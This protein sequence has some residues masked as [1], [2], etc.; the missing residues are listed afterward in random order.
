LSGQIDN[1]RQSGEELFETN[2]G[3]PFF[4]EN[5]MF[6][7]T[8]NKSIEVLTILLLSV[9]TI[10]VPVEVFLRYCF[11]M[12]LNITEQLTRYLLVWVVFLA[13]SLAL[14]ENSH[15]SIEILANRFHGRARLLVNLI[16]Q[17]V[18]ITFLAFLI[19]EGI[20]AL[21]FQKDQIV[22]SL[23]ISIFWFYLAIPV[24]S[25]LMIL[26]LLPRIW[27]ILKGISG[28]SN[29]DQKDGNVSPSEPGGFL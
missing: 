1:E 14:R 29:L 8:L 13:S 25:S 19:V 22:P 9:I 16:S 4:L 21:S 24:G 7:R 20:I 15:I 3:L 26:N 27:E 6:Y 18:L 2:T 5:N 10:I 23:R 12:T 28:K 11:G 17:I